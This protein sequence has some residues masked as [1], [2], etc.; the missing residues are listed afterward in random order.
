MNKVLIKFI[1]TGISISIYSYTFAEYS[2]FQ[3]NILNKSEGVKLRNSYV[4]NYSHN[5]Q[6][7]FLQYTY[8]TIQI[9]M[10]MK[11][12]DITRSLYATAIDKIISDLSYN[13]DLS[14]E[15]EVITILKECIEVNSKYLEVEAQCVPKMLWDGGYKQ[16]A[17]CA[18]AN[19][20]TSL[21]YCLGK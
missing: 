3:N 4:N 18:A 21:D 10:A 13:N 15:S 8:D 2:M 9:H 12:R 5:I 14:Y 7:K 19:I 11:L 20:K 1:I 6:D 17:E 16:Y